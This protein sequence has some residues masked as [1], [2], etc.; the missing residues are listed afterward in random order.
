MTDRGH[1]FQDHLW[2]ERG[3][4]ACLYYCDPGRAGQ[5]GGI[6]NRHR[7]IRRIVLKGRSIT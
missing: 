5:K 7:L 3:G 4:R 6:E 2:I 1:K